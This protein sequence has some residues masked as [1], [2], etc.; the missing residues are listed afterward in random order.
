[1]IKVSV[2]NEKTNNVSNTNDKINTQF[3]VRRNVGNKYS[4]AGLGRTTELVL[5]PPSQSES[6]LSTSSQILYVPK[7]RTALALTTKYI[8][9][10]E[11]DSNDFL[12]KQVLTTLIIILKVLDLFQTSTQNIYLRN[13]FLTQFKKTAV[14]LFQFCMQH[15]IY[16]RIG[17]GF[18]ESKQLKTKIIEH[19]VLTHDNSLF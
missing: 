2:I 19:L 5:P 9:N 14:Y 13:I 3:Q 18:P 8:R 16:L 11:I 15:Q 4:P 17:I 1:M 12:C 7:F 10:Q 6:P